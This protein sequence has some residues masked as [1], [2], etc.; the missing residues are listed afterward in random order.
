MALDQLLQRFMRSQPWQVVL[1]PGAADQAIHDIKTAFRPEEEIA[2][3]HFE[4]KLADFPVRLKTEPLSVPGHP[5]LGTKDPNIFRYSSDPQ[6][7]IS[8]I[9]DLDEQNRVLRATRIKIK[10]GGKHGH[11]G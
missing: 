1:A 8:V 11:H 9:A 10:V 3:A 6:A 4:H 7:V 5:P 2:L